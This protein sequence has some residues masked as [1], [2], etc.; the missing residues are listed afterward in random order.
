MST[1]PMEHRVERTPEQHAAVRR[2]ALPAAVAGAL[3]GLT[4]VLLAATTHVTAFVP[5]SLLGA[6]LAFCAMLIGAALLFYVRATPATRLARALS[7]AA[8]L[9]G[10]VGTL[11]Y[12]WQSVQ[13]R[14]RRETLEL[15]H[16]QAIARAAA[17]YATAYDG[18]FPPDLLTLLATQQLQPQTLQSPFGSWHPWLADLAQAPVGGTT[19]LSAWT[20][21]QRAE[22]LRS[23]ETESD[24]LYLGGDLTKVPPDSARDLI[25]A[26][27]RNTVLRSS[28]AVAFADGTSRFLTVEE[29]PPAIAR[30]NAARRK[31]GLDNLRL[32]AILQSAL[33]ET[34]EPPSR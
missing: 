14:Q 8:L 17:H 28:L 26:V 3:L 13:S 19:T 4:S 11:Q 9:L 1:G 27:S 18:L 32:P 21:A 25:V 12:S 10:M 34:K 20:G 31:M 33:D 6:N 22:L 23:L 29:V 5:P 24:Y 2:R 30:C 15:A 16:V 7:L